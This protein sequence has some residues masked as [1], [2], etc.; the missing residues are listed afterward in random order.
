MGVFLLAASSTGEDLVNSRPQWNFDI[1]P[2]S[3]DEVPVDDLIQLPISPAK[4]NSPPA[5]NT[6]ENIINVEKSSPNSTAKSEKSMLKELEAEFIA[7]EKKIVAS[8]LLNDLEKLVKSEGN[9][10]AIKLLENLEKALGVNRESNAELLAICFADRN[11]L[12]KSPT[13]SGSS[14]S[15]GNIKDDNN[16]RS[17]E[18]NADVEFA[19]FPTDDKCHSDNFNI[20]KVINK[21]DK[22]LKLVSEKLDGN[23]SRKLPSM[24][25]MDG[26]SENINDSVNNSINNIKERNQI[27]DDQQLALELLMGLGKLLSGEKKDPMTANLL[28]NL[29][30]AL[31]LASGNNRSEGNETEEEPEQPKRLGTPMKI[32][33]STPPRKSVS[34]S[35]FSR[36]LNRKSLEPNAK[37]IYFYT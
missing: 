5:N 11:D 16:E 32:P 24:N 37:V 18:D 28:K 2:V 34:I 26:S 8:T 31:N 12:T 20:P 21:S 13:R 30:T 29:G 17:C 7:P 19:E 4:Q 14:L 33:V 3:D 36:T 25:T 15:N 35:S 9:S 23:S 10:E 1:L 27:T 6:F 22:S